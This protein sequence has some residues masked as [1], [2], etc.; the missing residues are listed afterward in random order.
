MCWRTQV[1][2]RFASEYRKGKNELLPPTNSELPGMQE[3]T[4][5]VF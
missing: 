3:C 4:Q 2:V 5:V 1:R